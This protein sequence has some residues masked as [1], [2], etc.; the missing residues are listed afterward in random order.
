MKPMNTPGPL[1]LGLSMPRHFCL[2]TPALALLCSL[3]LSN[4]VVQAAELKQAPTVF[5]PGEQTTYQVSVLG[6]VAG[7]A[8]LT[9]GWKMEQ[10][11]KQVWPLVCVGETTGLAGLW[12][13]RD[14]FV[15]YWDPIEQHPWGADFYVNENRK[16]RKERYAYDFTAGNA[17]VTRQSEGHAPTERDF[18]IAPGTIDLA[19]AGF[20]LRNTPMVPGAV[21]SWPIFTGVKSYTMKATVVGREVLDS[22]LGKV[23]VH[24]VTV[25]GDF[26][27]NMSTKG[28]ITLFYSADEKQLPIRAEAEFLFGTVRLEAIK[29]E[30][31]WREAGAL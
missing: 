23:A 29:Y 16:R 24:R 9:V 20:G 26:N 18:D 1:A 12:S 21:Y 2:W 28:L 6:L 7:R 10:F 8:Q 17:H 14:R 5:A 4:T 19:S 15:S 31:G 30:P 13:I 25:N 3:A 22:A 27:G 11:G